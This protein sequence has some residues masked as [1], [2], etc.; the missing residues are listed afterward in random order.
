MPDAGEHVEDLALELGRHVDAVR[1]EQRKVELAS[2]RDRSLVARLLFA[3][4]V[5]L[6][7]DVDVLRA[8]RLDQTLQD[9]TPLVIAAA[10]QGCGE[11]AFL[12]P[13]HADQTVRILLDCAEKATPS[14]LLPLD[15][16]DSPVLR[17]ARLSATCEE[18]PLKRL[19]AR[20]LLKVKVFEERRW[21]LA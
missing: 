9:A 15:W 18:A 14:P 6:Q 21:P 5:P 7:L 1:R 16:K 17:T 8:E 19:M 20:T 4:A 13:G 11:R 10:L 3:N 2:E 12:T